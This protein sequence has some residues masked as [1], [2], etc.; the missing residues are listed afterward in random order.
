M[1]IAAVTR[2]RAAQSACVFVA[3]LAPACYAPSHRAA[4]AAPRGF[5]SFRFASERNVTVFMR[6]FALDTARTTLVDVTGLGG[7]VAGYFGDTLL[8][9]PYY[10]TMYDAGRADRRRTFGRGGVYHLPDIALVVPDYGL[11]ISDYALPGSNQSRRWSE[12]LVV[13]PNLVLFFGLTFHIL[14]RHW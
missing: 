4:A 5:Y 11:D 7:R 14:H 6:G 9:E 13:V 2:R 3:M 1:N 8:V 12:A 10:L